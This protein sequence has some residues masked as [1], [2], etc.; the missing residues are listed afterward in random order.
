MLSIANIM[1]MLYFYVN[2]DLVNFSNN[3][4]VVNPDLMHAQYC[5]YQCSVVGFPGCQSSGIIDNVYMQV[6][7]YLIRVDG[8]LFVS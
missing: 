1:M 7:T 4:W 8:E 5:H 2:C 6:S 3:L